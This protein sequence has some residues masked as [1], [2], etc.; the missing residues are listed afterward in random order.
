MSFAFFDIPKGIGTFLAGSSVYSHIRLK[1]EISFAVS[2]RMDGD[3]AYVVRSGPCGYKKRIIKGDEIEIGKIRIVWLGKRIGILGSP[4]CYE[5]VFKRWMRDVSKDLELED[6]D[7]YSLFSPVP[8]KVL[9]ID[10]TD[11]ELDSPPVR[12]PPSK[13]SIMLAAGPALTMAIPILIGASRSI[14][15]LS[16]LFAALWAV[17]NVLS[18]KKKLRSEEAARR[19]AYRQYVDE[20]EERIRGINRRNENA[21]RAYFPPIKEYFKYDGNP[22]LMWNRLINDETYLKYRIGTGSIRCPRN[23]KVPKDKYAQVDDSLKHLPVNLKRKY[24]YLND[25]PICVDF[26]GGSSWGMVAKDTEYLIK[27]MMSLIIQ[28][29]VSN[30]PKDVKI[31]VYIKGYNIEYSKL[32]R[33]INMPH[34]WDGSRCLLKIHEKGIFE[35]PRM[36]LESV[37]KVAGEYGNT[38]VFTD[39]ETLFKGLNG[40]LGVNPIFVTSDFL[41]LPPDVSSVIQSD[42]KF[43]G[44]YGI[45]NNKG[46]RVQARLDIIESIDVKYYSLLMSNL[47]PFTNKKG[48][49]IEKTITPFDLCGKIFGAA[50]I[51]DNWIRSSTRHSIKIPIG[52]YG[53]NEKLY[54]DMHEK[55]HGPHGL[56]AGMTGSGKSE[57]LSTIILMLSVMYA[58]DQVGFMLIDYKGG[59]MAGL[60]A[61][62]PHL[63]GSI[64][65]LSGHMINR[66]LVS[67]KSENYRRQRIFADCGINNIQEYTRLYEKKE[68]TIALPHVFIIVDEFAELK[69]EEP[70]FMN[71]LISVAQVGRSLGIHLILSTQKPA[72][73]VDDRIWSNSRFRLCLKMQ[74][75]SDSMDM[76][77]KADASL[78]KN[79]GCG[80]FQVGNDEIYEYFKG[81]YTQAKY[82]TKVK[83][84]LADSVLLYDE[85]AN[86]IDVKSILKGEKSED[87]KY[88]SQLNYLLKRIEDAYNQ[89]SEN[90]NLN[91]GKMWQEPLDGTMILDEKYVFEHPFIIGKYDNLQKSEQGDLYYDVDCMAHT[92]IIGMDSSGKS[93][94]FQ[95]I[96]IGM[97]LNCSAD[98]LN[99]Y[100]I[101][102]GGRYLENMSDSNLCGGYISEDEIS[103]LGNLMCFFKRQIELRKKLF[104]GSTFAEEKGRGKCIPMLLL[105]IDNYSSFVECTK[106][107]YEKVIIDILRMG[108]KLGI[109]LMVSARDISVKELPQRMFDN[110]KYVYTLRLLDRFHYSQILRCNISNLPSV[111]DEIGHGIVKYREEFVEYTVLRYFSDSIRK[112]ENT[113]LRIIENRNKTNNVKALEYPFIPVRPVCEDLFLRIK[114]EKAFETLLKKG[115]PIGYIKETGELYRLPL[116]NQNRIVLLGKK[117]SGRHTCMSV[118]ALVAS[119]Y[120]IATCFI[121]SIG[122]LA[123]NL[124]H[125]SNGRGKPILMLIDNFGQVIQKF[126]EKEYDR[127]TEEEIIRRITEQRSQ[128]I[129]V[130]LSPTDRS[131]LSGRRIYETFIKDSYG[132]CFGGNLDAQN[133]YDFSY[134][135]YSRQSVKYPPGYATVPVISQKLFS[136]DVIIPNLFE[137][138]EE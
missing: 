133:I 46:V 98:G 110:F 73:V 82:E 40:L 17:I 130:S 100:I 58:P 3:Y 51:Y 45:S 80:Y 90:R 22:Y 65:N 94:L 4:E 25:V 123:E 129:V 12:K 121:T 59:G 85:Y 33:L 93:T 49:E 86:L 24:E 34:L 19:K 54:L 101:D 111:I 41:R 102:L 81:A 62:L 70:D 50:D 31:C 126:Y 15:V 57:L 43:T 104:R 23:I 67:I 10:T 119:R 87:G 138:E 108:E 42:D 14:A 118:I 96:L 53:E 37:E 38:Y 63:M 6:K 131:Y 74:D 106:N 113:I 107:E 115:L 5:C 20:C 32:Y 18:R 39:D 44:W 128:V 92:A 122:A 47:V 13:P 114:K 136:G 99:M 8:R 95:N 137:A 55:S 124:K 28:I 109:V 71:Q 127:I 75:K 83:G 69:R 1:E 91:V 56:V 117:G 27:M 77:H 11:V 125:E 2:V 61:N 72:G 16:T 135:G 29:C 78:I 52:I 26:S 9:E 88:E 132:L 134:L 76:L 103:R 64:S 48:S 36:I 84:V 60:F 68:V 21:L 105:A 79:A 120:K 89:Y 112:R 30:H 116:E 97:I 66:A 35:H 7:E